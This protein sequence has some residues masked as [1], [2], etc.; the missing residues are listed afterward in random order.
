MSS[1]IKKYRLIPVILLTVLLITLVAPALAASTVIQE[2]GFET[3]SAW[4]YSETDA[5][6]SGGQS[7]VWKT[8]GGYSYQF[9]STANIS[10]AAYS[11][12]S[13]TVDFSILD[14]L[15]FDAYLWAERAGD[16]TASVRV[17]TN[18]VWSIAVPTTA[19]QYLKQTI[20][21]SG[22]SG[23]QNLAFRITA[24]ANTGKD[25]INYFDN[26]KTWGSFNDTG[27]TTR[28]NNFANS[29]HTAYMF[30]EGFTPSQTYRVI[31]WDEV[32]PD[33]YNRGTLDIAADVNGGLSGQHTFNQEVDTAG[34]WY[35]AVYDSTTYSPV[36]YDPNDSHLI[37]ADGFTVEQSAIP[38]FSDVIG[39]VV[40][41][42]LCAG[43][44]CCMKKRRLGYAKA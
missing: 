44:Y 13:Q 29:D 26:I 20:D 7:T 33:W 35:A 10:S 31:F 30:G 9:S 3:I 24:N 1:L 12:I 11:Q 27:H 25:Q 2:M 19:T 5:D 8:E 16:F 18:Q 32:T 23:N 4:T 15:S 28:T 38:E 14:T 42:V 17:G 36:T 43:I 40:I 6:F 22:Y 41:V 21:V 34:T 39:P 37:V